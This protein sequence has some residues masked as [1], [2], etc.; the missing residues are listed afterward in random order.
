M[1]MDLNMW[2]EELVDDATV[3]QQGA[4]KAQNNFDTKVFNEKIL[5]QNNN[6]VVFIYGSGL[7]HNPSERQQ[8]HDSKLVCSFFFSPR[9]IL[10]AP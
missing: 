6:L 2:E 8:I 7:N 3:V 1:R 4:V 10:L 5:K 9:F